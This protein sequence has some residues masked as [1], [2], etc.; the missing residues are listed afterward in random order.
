MDELVRLNIEG[1]LFEVRKETLLKIPY[2]YNL[3]ETSPPINNEIS[4]I[5]RSARIFTCFTMGSL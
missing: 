1:Q 3:F 2:F 5:D 4:H